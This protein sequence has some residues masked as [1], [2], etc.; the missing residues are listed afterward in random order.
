MTR[1]NE[2]ITGVF[3]LLSV[4]LIVAASLWLSESRWRGEYRS[5]EASFANVGQLREGNRVSLRGVEVGSVRSIEFAEEGVRVTL[6]IREEAPLPPNP[7]VVLRPLSLFGGWGAAIVSGAERPAA[8]A[9]AE[10]LP[11]GVVPGV[12]SSDFAQLSDHTGEIAANLQSITDRLEIAFNEQTAANVADAVEN[13]ETASEELAVLM[14]QQRES[15]G[16]FAADMAEAGTTLRSAA[17]DLDSTMNRLESAT[18]GGELSSI[19][20]NADE[21]AASLRRVSERLGTTTG[22]MSRTLTR[23]DS[24]FTEAEILLQRLNQGEGSL[25]RL[26]TDPVLYE[27]FQATLTELNALLDDLRRNPAKYFSFSIF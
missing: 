18:A 5:L 24:A 25:G 13:F 26:T 1:K 6:R 15:F 17:A 11:A 19:F 16:G 9:A 21:A 3:V 12:T 4:A 8:A 20:R 10:D 2:I 22:E 27:D 23:A 14:V 7:V